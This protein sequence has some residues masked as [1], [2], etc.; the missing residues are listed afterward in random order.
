[1]QPAALL[2]FGGVLCLTLL[3]PALSILLRTLGCSLLLAILPRLARPDRVSTSHAP[4]V[5]YQAALSPST[6]LQIAVTGCPGPEDG[7]LQ[8]AGGNGTAS[9]DENLKKWCRYLSTTYP[10]LPHLCAAVGWRCISVLL[11]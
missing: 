7:E 8:I 2:W 11:D 9:F 10:V 1:M 5:K 3:W 6:R 4:S